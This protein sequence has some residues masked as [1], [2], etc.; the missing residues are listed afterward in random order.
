MATQPV[1][2]PSADVRAE[3]RRMLQTFAHAFNTGDL[4]TVVNFYEP[5]ATLLPPN[6]PAAEGI[7]AI[8]EVFKAF[9]EA[10]GL[11]LKPETVRVEQSGDLVVEVG[12][13][14][15][16][17]PDPQGGTRPDRGKYVTVLRRQRNGELKLIV[18]SWSS[19]LPQE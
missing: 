5:D 13:Y 11:D 12:R 16:N 10:G 8:R 2:R 15:A 6:A 3:I 7:T 1:S 4:E 19:D 18:D 9:R 14:T 17:V